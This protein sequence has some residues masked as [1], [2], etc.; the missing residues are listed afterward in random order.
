ADAGLSRSAF[1]RQRFGWSDRGWPLSGRYRSSRRDF[2]YWRQDQFCFRLRQRKVAP[3]RGAK[4]VSYCARAGHERRVPLLR[5]R[6]WLSENKI[7]ERGR[8]ALAGVGGQSSA[9][10]LFRKVLQQKLKRSA[11]SNRLPAAAPSGLLAARGQWPLAAAHFRPLRCPQ[12][13]P[14]G[15][16]RQLV[17]GRSLL[18]LAHT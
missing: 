8:P 15:D 7:L 16:A 12:R 18:Q 9:G 17:R 11:A 1:H 13:N 5:R 14:A 4:A 3:P 2:R 6:W 10:T